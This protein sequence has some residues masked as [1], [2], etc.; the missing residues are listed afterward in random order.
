LLTVRVTAG[1][2][3]VWKKSFE[4]PSNFSGSLFKVSSAA[5]PDD[6]F[7]AAFDLYSPP[8]GVGVMKITNSGKVVWKKR[9]ISGGLVAQSAG[10][11]ADGGVILFG[12]GT[13]NKLKVVVLNANG[14]LSWDAG[15]ILK[16]QGRI[17]PVSSS[18][19]T[20]DGGYVVTGSTYYGIKSSGFIVKIDSSRK[21][22]FQSTFGNGLALG[23]LGK[24]IFTTQDG[25]FFLFGATPARSDGEAGTIA[26]DI[27]VLKMNSEGVVPGC[28]FF[29]SSSTATTA[30]YGQFRIDGDKL[31]RSVEL[32]LEIFDF[33]LSS[34]VTNHSVTTVCQ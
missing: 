24:S 22:A 17:G 5:T 27:V 28:D 13:G 9:L 4:L 11:T 14:T 15:Y 12:V 32:S 16:V 1:G 21:V 23:A 20:P 29:G 19:Q 8:F 7:I 33:G 10:V 30:S 6:G 3:V 26:G 34:V 18:V 31:S 25:G 2:D